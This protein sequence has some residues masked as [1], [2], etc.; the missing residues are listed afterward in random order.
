MRSASHPHAFMGVNPH[1]LASIVRTN[2]NPH[3]H[4]ILRGSSDGPNYESKYVKSAAT[5]MS[6]ARPNDHPSIMI[7]CSHGN[8]EKDYRNQPKVLKNVCEQLQAGDR[9]ITGV[10]IESHFNAGA[11]S[12]PKE[13]PAGLKYGMLALLTLTASPEHA[14]IATATVGVSITDSCVDF[15]TTLTMLKELNDVRA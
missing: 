13:G 4:V 10:M 11:Q 7:D 2:G 6:K 1:G 3:L 9:T 12:I 15:D 5:A 14:N 8:S